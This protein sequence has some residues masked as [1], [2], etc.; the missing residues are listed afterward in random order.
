MHFV[1]ICCG[2]HFPTV[3]QT[4]NPFSVIAVNSHYKYTIL[5]SRTV[6]S[7]TMI[8][9][10]VLA[11]GLAI[12]S[13]AQESITDTEAKLSTTQLDHF[14]TITTTLSTLP[15]ASELPASA[16]SA[17]V[18]VTNSSPLYCATATAYATT[19]TYMERSETTTCTAYSIT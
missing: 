15:F 14:E 7:S 19:M 2:E 11:I 13:S 18:P 17:L 6:C 9:N 8:W 16:T 5:S 10:I 12:H 3:V 1:A 4:L